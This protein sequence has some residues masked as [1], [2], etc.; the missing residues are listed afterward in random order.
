MKKKKQGI[1]LYAFTQGAIWSGSKFAFK[2]FCPL[3]FW[4]MIRGT[5]SS[6]SP[7]YWSYKPKHLPYQRNIPSK[8]PKPVIGWKHTNLEGTLTSIQIS[9]QKAYSFSFKLLSNFA[10]LWL[11]G[12]SN[13]IAE[14]QEQHGLPI[15]KTSI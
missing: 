10:I 14:V 12:I 6:L 1:T 3:S 15:S 9:N 2:Y 13:F 11:K 8:E 4:M 7:K 5:W